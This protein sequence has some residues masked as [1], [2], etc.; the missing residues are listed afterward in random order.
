MRKYELL[1]LVEQHK[2][3]EKIYKMDELIKEHGHN[4]L[5]LPPYM[6]E[7]N[8]IEL[9]WAQVKRK[10]RERNISSNI[11][12]TDLEIFTRQAIGDV[13]PDQWKNLCAHV[14]KIEEQYWTR[15]N[16]L[17]N[18]MEDSALEIESTE[19]DESDESDESDDSTFSENL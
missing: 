13:T 8:L 3:S 19:T 9:A 15:D 12:N 18:L 1:D 5:R 11:S 16:L 10:I 2:K 17:E 7:F 14:E 4:V 6:C